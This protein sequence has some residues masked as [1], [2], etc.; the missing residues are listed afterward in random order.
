MFTLFASKPL[1]NDDES[2]WIFST[3]HWALIHFD[4]D[5]FFQRSRLIQPT[6]QFFKGQVDSHQA[7]AQTVFECCVKY[8]GLQHWPLQLQHPEQY[9]N[10]T[11]ELMALDSIE[12]ALKRNSQNN[13]LTKLVSPQPIVLTYNRHQTGKPE[14]LAATFTSHFAQH[15]IVQSQQL[16]P[17]GA[18][19]LVESSEVL[20][21]FMGFGVM[22][23]NS[24]YTYR[25]GC[26]SCYNAQA[27]R[28]AS[29]TEDKVVFAFALFCKLKNIPHKQA[30]KHLKKYL[31][32]LY[33]QAA[34]QID[35]E[36]EKVQYLLDLNLQK[37]LI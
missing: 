27:N 29:L 32:S 2:Q 26:G 5:E 33:K 25:G 37:Q 3:F 30:M 34:K 11:A 14:D 35:K 1:L 7:L 18:N 36:P 24:A 8:A 31:R 10:Q 13:N 12:G 23:C 21:V 4:K 19:L 28:S 22:M 17:G 20:A 15:L 9:T 16:P 6:D